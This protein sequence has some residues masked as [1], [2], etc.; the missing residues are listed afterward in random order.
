MTKARFTL[1]EMLA[2]AEQ[3]NSGELGPAPEPEQDGAKGSS[4]GSGSGTGTLGR[5]VMEVRYGGP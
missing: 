5:A 4:E 3:L 1:E 2:E